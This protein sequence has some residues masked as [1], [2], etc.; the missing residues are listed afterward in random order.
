MLELHHKE[1]ASP[2][3]KS[4]A[5][6]TRPSFNFVDLSIE[7][8]RNEPLLASTSHP[9]NVV[10]ITPPAGWLKSKPHPS[11]ADNSSLES[12][13]PPGNPDVTLNRY[14]RG[15][16][17]NDQSAAA[18]RNILE[19]K[20]ATNQEQLLSPSEIKA[21]SQVFGQSS[22]GDN[23]YSNS[24]KSGTSAS[25]AFEL[26]VAYTKQI[27]G[28]PGVVVEGRF[29]DADGTPQ[30]EFIGAFIDST[31]TGKVVQEVY[32]EGSSSDRANANGFLTS[33]SQFKRSL[34]D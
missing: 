2:S 11:Q 16:E 7:G 4:A 14:Y 9:T 21:L 28:K 17:L 27:K 19:K 30:K 20:P 15:H 18:F 29:V 13:S 12:F 25:P 24:T 10:E 1:I 3:E 32:L 5:D 23:Q 31:G 33:R 6:E 26:D 8:R 22:V 34:T